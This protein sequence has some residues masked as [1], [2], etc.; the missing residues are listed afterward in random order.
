MLSREN[1]MSRKRQFHWLLIAVLLSLGLVACQM[2]EAAPEAGAE[3][4]EEPETQPESE[5]ATSTE[6]ADEPAAEEPAELV[7]E[8][9]PPAELVAFAIV[10]ERSQARF[11]IDE[12]LGGVAT[13]VVGVTSDLTGTLRAN[14]GR[15]GASEFDP[16]V[17]DANT[18]VTPSSRRDGAIRNFV[19]YTKLYP[20]ITFG[21]A[22]VEN[23]PDSV[24]VGEE[25]TLEVTGPLYVLDS[26]LEVTFLVTA[27][28]NSEKELTGT[29][30]TTI[31]LEEHGIN[32]PRPPLVS[33]V[34]DKMILELDFVA[35]AE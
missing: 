6:V 14:H 15:I 5:T 4:V 33:W 35:K 29:G 25:F 22:R 12:T 26:D 32:V 2:P 34:D 11:I 16:I 1:A 28:F 20:E 8:E 7:E 10:G 30:S 3:A 19:L 9:V 18:F 27:M 31:I 21:P 13:K 23:A 17:I 24:A